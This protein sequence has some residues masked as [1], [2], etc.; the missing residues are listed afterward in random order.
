MGTSNACDAVLKYDPTAPDYDYIAGYNGYD[1][2]IVDA[3]DYSKDIPL[4]EIDDV[5]KIQFEDPN[6]FNADQYNPP[7]GEALAA[8]KLDGKVG[9]G[10]KYK[11][12]TLNH[13]L[14]TNNNQTLLPSFIIIGVMKCGT[15]AVNKFLRFHP[16]LRTCGETYFFSDVNYHKGLDWYMSIMPKITD[17]NMHKQVYEKTP[18]YYRTP[19]IA[20]RI[21]DMNSTIKLIYVGMLRNIFF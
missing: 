7:G 15:G 11:N 4:T 19:K 21:H 2:G 13:L 1:G 3:N 14:K 20:K 17:N 18:T 8:R 6:D 16:D 9:I 5:A 12:Q 10:N